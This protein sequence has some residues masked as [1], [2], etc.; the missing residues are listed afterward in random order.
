MP[1]IEFQPSAF[2]PIRVVREVKRL[3][4]AAVDAVETY[5]AAPVPALTVVI[6][7]RPGL[8]TAQVMAARVPGVK[9][10]HAAAYW[11][12]TWCEAR[13]GFAYTSVT[14]TDRILIGVNAPVLARK[15]HE[16]WP[17][18]VHELVHAVQITRPGRRA[19]LQAGMDNNL[20]VSDS[21]AH[22]RYAMDAIVAIE[23]AEAYQVQYQLDPEAELASGFDRDATFHRMVTAVSHWQAAPE[24]QTTRV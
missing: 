14:R 9:A 18:L 4:P 21:P 5:L 8:A 10:R 19:E 2:A 20:R 12:L 15:P 22:L 7:G 24:P 6:A 23:E 17:T 3:L 1:A 13:G 16:V 11:H